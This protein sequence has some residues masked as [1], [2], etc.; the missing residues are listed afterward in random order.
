MWEGLPDGIWKGKNIANSDLG[1]YYASARVVLND[2]HPSMLAGGFVNNRIFDVLAC[3]VPVISDKIAG[4]PREI[5]EFVYLAE[6]ADELAACLDAALGEDET[7]RKRRVEIAEYVRAQHSFDRRA[8]SI[9]SKIR[10]ILAT[11]KPA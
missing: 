7:R 4:L 2:H 9:E 3:G 1:R 8:E 11:R 5:A 10:A 6:T